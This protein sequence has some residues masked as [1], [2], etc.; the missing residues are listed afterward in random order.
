MRIDP[1][2]LTDRSS[3]IKA[4]AEKKEW[5][6]TRSGYPIRLVRFH[7]PTGERIEFCVKLRGAWVNDRRAAKV[8]DALDQINALILADKTHRPDRPIP[9]PI[10]E[11]PEL[12]PLE[13]PGAAQV[14]FP[15]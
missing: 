1:V 2:T 11:Q 6:G 15:L 3:I 14:V 7:S 9:R 5:Q 13:S 4:L 12:W 10:A 8:H